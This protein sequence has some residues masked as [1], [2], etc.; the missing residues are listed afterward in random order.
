[1]NATIQT[2]AEHCWVHLIHSDVRV[3]E[4][5]YTSRILEAGNPSNP[6]LFYCMALAVI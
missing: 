2:Q 4:G 1:M 6:P 3:I 5:K